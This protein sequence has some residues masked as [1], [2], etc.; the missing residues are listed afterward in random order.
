MILRIFSLN[1]F[2]GSFDSDMSLRRSEKKDET[3]VKG[4]GAIGL[5]DAVNFAGLNYSALQT[6]YR[7]CR[8]S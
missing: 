5:T 1:C 2:A 7:S 4:N 6:L 3:L 8:T